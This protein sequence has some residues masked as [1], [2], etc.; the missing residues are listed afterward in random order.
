MITIIWL[1]CSILEFGNKMFYV[2]ATD[3][4]PEPLSREMEERSNL[5]VPR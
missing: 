5:M 2:G 1:V 3:V 4:L